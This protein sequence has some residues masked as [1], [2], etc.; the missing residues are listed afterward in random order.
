MNRVNVYDDGE[1]VGWFD[2]D[3]AQRLAADRRGDPYVTYNNVYL[4]AGGKLIL[5]ESTNTEGSRTRFSLCSEAL[6]VELIIASGTEE[7]NVW[8]ECKGKEHIAKR[9]L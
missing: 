4:T 2:L 6:A 5:S 7:G 3:A 9:E 1:Y 8:L